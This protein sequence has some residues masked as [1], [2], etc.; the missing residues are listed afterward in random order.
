[1][2]N[3]HLAGVLK[4]IPVW[5]AL[6]VCFT[7][8]S[9]AQS[10]ASTP[11]VSENEPTEAVT[12]VDAPDDFTLALI[13]WKGDYDE[14]VQ[15]K[16]IRIVV[17][18]SPT[19][20]F[21]D[22]ATERGIVA[23]AGRQLER[24]INRREGLRTRLVH[25]VFIP[26]RQS[27]LIQYLTDGLGDI[28][29]GNLTITDSRQA[30]VDFSEPVLR[31]SEE[32]IVTGPGAPTIRTIAEL[33]GK[34]VYVQRSSSYNDSLRRLSRELE[35]KGASPIIIQAADELLEPDEIVEM[36][37][38]GLFPA[39]VVDRHL[40]EF[41]GQIFPDLTV[42]SDLVVASGQN[43]AWAFR[44]ESPKLEEVLNEFVRAHRHRTQFGNQLFRR[45]LQNTNWV[46]NTNASAERQR[47][48]T[49][50][51]LFTK[52][53]Q[54]Y[55]LDPLLLAALGYQESRLNQKAQSPA[56][57]IGVM[58]LLPNTGEAMKV[59]DI[60]TL[61]PNIHAG[62]RYLHQLVDRVSSPEVDPLNRIFF[63]LASYNA[64]QTRIR[65]LRRETAANGL[66]P[67][68]WVNNVELAV[69]R[70]IGRET[71]Q[72]VRNIYKYY[73]AY[74]RVEAKRAQRSS[75]SAGPSPAEEKGASR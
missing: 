14:M 3:T 9:H 12:P 25:V 64:G 35:Q 23:T 2:R 45:Y 59:G 28:A 31:N 63:A 61:E 58:Q 75:R 48:D 39:T 51:P 41:W 36:V 27:Q 54:Q 1:M 72:Y 7:S 6:M 65:R 74:Q 13:P 52:Y 37:Q 19:H 21:L 55:E 49:T 69:A 60:K 34:E 38:A 44:K 5:V 40:A 56:G 46:R 17:A 66:D 33:A 73:L 43:I 10:P 42:R 18:Y 71:V 24:E 30:K 4:R 62:T 20:Y 15:R 68:V 29:A 11:D 53:G 8:I 22:G 47:F 70:E 57:A 32:I 50:L 16:M 26:V 67:N